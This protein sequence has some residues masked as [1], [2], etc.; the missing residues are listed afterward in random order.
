MLKSPRMREIKQQVLV[1]IYQKM[2]Q[3][4]REA[5]TRNPVKPMFY[6][7]TQLPKT[8]HRLKEKDKLNPRNL[9]GMKQN[10][11]LAKFLLFQVSLP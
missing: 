2:Y 11:F 10:Q 7:K 5:L 3:G 8:N 1:L 9:K 4:C 6:N